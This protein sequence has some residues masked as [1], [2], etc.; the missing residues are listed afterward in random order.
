MS[1]PFS[2]INTQS[3]L[4]TD[5]SGE[6]LI[7]MLE[8]GNPIHVTAVELKDFLLTLQGNSLNP[9]KKH[10]TSAPDIKSG[11][12]VHVYTETLPHLSERKLA[13][14]TSVEPSF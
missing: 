8:N 11:E 14:S 2:V 3:W 10:E 5:L 7:F 4:R 6:R 13:P 12:T 9:I 1:Y